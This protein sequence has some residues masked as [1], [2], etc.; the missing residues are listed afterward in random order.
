VAPDNAS[1]S[2][3]AASGP[4][5]PVHLVYL[6]GGLLLFYLLKWTADWI[7]GYFTRSP[8]VLY[9][10]VLSAA[11]AL[12]TGI[13]LYRNERVYGLV[14]EVCGELKKVSWPTAKEVKAATVV[15]VI[16]TIISAI[17]LGLFDA[18]WSNI[19]ELIYG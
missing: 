16:M 9:V 17:I 8:S 6:C 15:V 4:N 2:S 14:N 1:R 13:T 12:V 7:W 10:T 19:T 5:K 3:Y 11:I 18:M